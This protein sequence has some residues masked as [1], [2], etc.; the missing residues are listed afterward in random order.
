[1]RSRMFPTRTGTPYLLKPP[2]PGGTGASAR[3]PPATTRPT[4]SGLDERRFSLNR[5]GCN[6][7]KTA[8]T[9]LICVH[10]TPHWF[11]VGRPDV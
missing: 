6:V 4:S 3:R 7:A 1:M 8:R 5:S 2:Q 9:T 10:E 11:S